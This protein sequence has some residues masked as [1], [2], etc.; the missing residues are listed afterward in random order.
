MAAPSTHAPHDST[1]SPGHDHHD[2]AHGHDAGE[3]DAV[4]RQAFDAES[5]QEL[6][7]EDSEAW[8]NVT[9]ELL[10]IVTIGVAFFTFIVWLISR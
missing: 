5:Q 10:T 3:A 2:D 7:Q 9:G 6:L 8:Y 4:F 1:S